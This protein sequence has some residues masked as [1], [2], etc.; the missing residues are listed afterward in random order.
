MLFIGER[1]VVGG[2]I[3]GLAFSGI[4]GLVLV[5]SLVWR[6][7]SWQNANGDVKR[8]ERWILLAYAGVLMSVIGFM[9]SSGRWN[10]PAG[11]RV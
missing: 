11:A 3:L 7:V 10:E 9:A 5:G 4:G 6:F 8:L 1:V 2:G